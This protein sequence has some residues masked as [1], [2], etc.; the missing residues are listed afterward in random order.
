MAEDKVSAKILAD[1]KNRVARINVEYREKIKKFESALEEQKKAYR[2]ETKRMAASEQE[3]IRR[4]L[5]SEARLE[6]RR[7]ILNAKHQLIVR[8]IDK[9]AERFT[10][11]KNYPALIA[12]TV[13]ASPKTSDVLLSA[14]D[15]K[16]LKSHS[17]ARKAKPAPIMGG[18]ILRT[19]GR[20]LNFSLDASFETLKESL[21][22]EIARILF[23]E[24]AP[25]DKGKAGSKK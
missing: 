10:S 14:D 7:E 11:S 1:A 15:L 6:A 17:W 20:D 12:K 23:D 19:P 22:L 9:A 8:V 24:T 2:E 3:R 13:A 25:G 18:V 5:L 4:E 21:T 16:R